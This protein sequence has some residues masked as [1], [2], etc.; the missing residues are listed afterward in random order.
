MRKW[1]LMQALKFWV[2]ITL[3]VVESTQERKQ[4]Q[5]GWEQRRRNRFSTIKTGLL[6]K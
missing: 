4:S 3:P 6:L 1:L 5:W 2:R